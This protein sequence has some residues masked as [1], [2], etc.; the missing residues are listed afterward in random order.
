MNKPF[1]HSYSAGKQYDQC[2]HRF[3]QDRVLRRFPFVQS[4]EAAEG[5]R[6][7]DALAKNIGEG[8]ALPKKYRWL[9]K[10]ATAATQRPGQNLVEQKWGLT[11]RFTPTGYYGAD[12]YYRYRNDYVNICPDG[13][14]AALLDWKT[15]SDKYPDE[16]QLVEGAVTLM[17]HYPKIEVVAAA[18]VFTK[19]T[20][21]LPSTYSRNHLD[22][23]VET[24]ASKYAEIDAALAAEEYPKKPGP[25]CPWCPVTECEFWR[26][27]PERRK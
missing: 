10:I 23:Y 15:G 1:V 21:F 12:V 16:D 25:L 7:H 2:P 11:K 27:K 17:S 3:H 5:D 4:E 19:T 18:L 26:P 22:D 8:V 6:I 20:K 9:R 14:T 13:T 24:M